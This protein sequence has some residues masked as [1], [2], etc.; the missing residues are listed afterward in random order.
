MTDALK[1]KDVWTQKEGPGLFYTEERPLRVQWDGG[2]YKS[3]KQRRVRSS[4]TITLD[5]QPS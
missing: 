2:I 4:G 3:K 5:L 1:S